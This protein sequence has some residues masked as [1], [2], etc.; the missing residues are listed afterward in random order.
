M[1]TCGACH[2]AVDANPR[3]PQLGALGIPPAEEIGTVPHMLRHKWAADQMWMGLVEPSDEN[4]SKG[5]A[6]LADAPL[7]PEGMSNDAEV[8]T[9]AGKLARRVHEIGAKAQAAAD[10]DA[11]ALI[12][13]DF[14]ATCAACHQVLSKGP[15]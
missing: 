11:R 8:S 12:Y 15:Q 14:L 2:K 3:I 6:V 4:W 7:E 5:V 13:G 1:K 9:E 10:P